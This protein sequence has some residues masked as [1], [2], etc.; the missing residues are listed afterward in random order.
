MKLKALSLAV[1][2]VTTGC[3]DNTNIL[4]QEAEGK[5]IIL[6]APTGEAYGDYYNENEEYEEVVFEEDEDDDDE[7]EHE[8]DYDGIDAGDVLLGAA[9]GAAL[10]N[11]GSGKSK[12][13]KTVIVH[14][15]P[16]APNT[17]LNGGLGAKP[18]VVKPKP[19]V[20]NPAAVTRVNVSNQLNNNSANSNTTNKI[21]N[22]NLSVTQQQARPIVKKKKK[23]SKR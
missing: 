10:A 19:L 18:P 8:S 23:K 21:T 6:D 11:S 14:T 7:D 13:T 12:V 4:E 1:I 2:L 15:P 17:G 16:R 22:S 5:V 9:V 3:G 20:A